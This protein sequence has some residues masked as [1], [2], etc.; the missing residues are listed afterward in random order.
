MFAS[1]M[2]ERLSLLASGTLLESL[3]YGSLT[4]DFRACEI[5]TG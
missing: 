4:N 2:I 3:R 1:G 5:A